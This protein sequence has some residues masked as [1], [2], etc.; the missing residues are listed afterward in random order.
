MKKINLLLL[1]ISFVGIVL[2]MNSC[3]DSCK[4]VDCLNGGVCVEGDCD[5]PDGFS[6]V[7]CGSDDSEKTAAIAV[8]LNPV[9]GDEPLKLYE[10]LL[11]EAGLPFFE[12]EKL[13]FYIS[14]LKLDDELVAEEIMLIDMNDSD[15]SVGLSKVKPGDYSSIN[16]GLGVEKRWNKEVPV[17]FEN[18]HPLGFDHS[19]NYWEMNNS[20]TFYKIEGKYS[21]KD[22]G[23]LDKSFL[24]HLGTDE[25]YRT[26]TLDKLTVVKNEGTTEITLNINFK[27]LLFDEGSI[28]LETEFSTHGSEDKSELNQKFAD[29]LIESIE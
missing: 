18:D 3:K 22:D 24:F 2:L 26:L 11:N 12:L 4:D 23:D 25:L 20:Y 21:S 16:F 7:D 28:D 27:K 29:R 6:G 13:Y 10:P 19:S 14:D 17:S 8:K 1:L 5:C 9:F 15:L